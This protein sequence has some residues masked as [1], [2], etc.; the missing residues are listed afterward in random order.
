MECVSSI[1]RVKEP[2]QTTPTLSS[3]L[4]LTYLLSP[5]NSACFWIP[6]TSQY[7][8]TNTYACFLLKCSFSTK[9]IFCCNRKKKKNHWQGRMCSHIF[10]PSFC[11][12]VCLLAVGH[13]LGTPS[14]ANPK[15]GHHACESCQISEQ[16]KKSGDPKVQTVI[17]TRIFQ[18]RTIPQMKLISWYALTEFP[19][20]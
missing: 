20:M 2:T 18:S 8:P 5:S 14:S 6:H 7:F 10:A 15:F 17:Y 19:P 4:F 16:S 11:L 9:Q 3:L 1:S 12:L 13:V